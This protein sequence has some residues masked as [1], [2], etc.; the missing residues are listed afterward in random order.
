MLLPLFPASDLADSL[1]DPH[2]VFAPQ[3]TVPGLQC[4]AAHPISILLTIKKKPIPALESCLLG[5]IPMF[6]YLIALYSWSN[7]I[8]QLR[9]KNKLTKEREWKWT[10]LIDK[11][12]AWWHMGGGPVLQPLLA[13]T[14]VRT[15]KDMCVATGTDTFT[16]VL[17][18][19]AQNRHKHSIWVYNA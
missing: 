7:V 6:R 9:E 12:Q 17:C 18:V 16:R 15:T 4:I 3:F 11:A 8:F 2:G 14:L 13:D 1:L 5:K 10:N 19:N